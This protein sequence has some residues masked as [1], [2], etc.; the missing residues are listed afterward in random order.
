MKNF[1]VVLISILALISCE[2]DI[3][4]FSPTNTLIELSDVEFQYFEIGIVSDTTLIGKDGTKIFF[5]RQNYNIN[6]EDSVTLRLK[7]FYDFND[8]VI[9]NISTITDKNELLETSGV[10][11]FEFSSNNKPLLLKE[12]EKIRVIFPSNRI[13]NNDI[14]YAN[15]DSLG[16]FEWVNESTTALITYPDTVKLKKYKVKGYNIEQEVPLDSL[17]YY[18]KLI[19]E[20]NI[21]QNEIDELLANGSEDFLN[22]MGVSVLLNKYNWIN[23][24]RFVKTSNW[25]S[26]T[27]D[28]EEPNLQ[29]YHSHII[30]KDF[31]SVASDYHLE[32]IIEFDSIPINGEIALFI[33]GEKDGQLFYDKIELDTQTKNYTSKMRKISL[34]DFEKLILKN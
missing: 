2:E 11:F 10:I 33:T 29:Y 25:L 19:K 13:N 8:I 21:V 31:N 17:A 6:I 5:S 3:K 9:N 23:I 26:F 15:I 18:Q 20:I 16:Q 34:D 4:E 12:N 22:N 14:F 28:I 1:I 7:E 32:N 24:D 30:Y 27:V